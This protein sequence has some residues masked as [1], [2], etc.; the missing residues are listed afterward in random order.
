MSYTKEAFEG[1][2][3][4]NITLKLVNKDLVEALESALVSTVNGNA[5]PEKVREGM[6]VALTKAKGGQA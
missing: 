3:N 1:L 2:M 4:E 6:I 5:I